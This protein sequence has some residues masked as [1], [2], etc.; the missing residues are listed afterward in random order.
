MN[1]EANAEPR[2]TV[3]RTVV[4]L[5]WAGAATGLFCAAYGQGLVRTAQAAA[6]RFPLLTWALE[7]LGGGAP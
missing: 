3:L 6:G 2:P 7:Q 5:L 4:S 1:S